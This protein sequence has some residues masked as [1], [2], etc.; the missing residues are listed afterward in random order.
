MLEE[1]QVCSAEVCQP[2]KDA[3]NA[4]GQADA[5]TETADAQP[6]CVEKARPLTRPSRASARGAGHDC[7]VVIAAASLLFWQVTDALGV[8]SALKA[9][10]L[11]IDCPSYIGA[12]PYTLQQ[13]CS[14][15]VAACPCLAI[16]TAFMCPGTCGAS[17]RRLSIWSYRLSEM[18]K[19]LAV[20]AA[21]GDASHAQPHLLGDAS[22]VPVEQH[23]SVSDPDGTVLLDAAFE[24]LPMLERKSYNGHGR[25]VIGSKCFADNG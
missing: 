12:Q 14:S 16:P 15:V 21:L 22:H 13:T 5:P 6:A 23:D 8:T 3:F 19:E 7:Y 10:G 1:S 11:S 20:Q 18:R 2:I 4:C 17:G 9:K 25:S 24:G